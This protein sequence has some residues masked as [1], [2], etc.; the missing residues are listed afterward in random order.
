MNEAQ[1]PPAPAVTRTLARYIVESNPD[2][3]PDAVVHEARRALLHWIGCSLGGCRHEATETALAA[4]G[5]FSG[6]REATVIGRPERVDLLLAALLNGISADVLGFSDTHLKTVIHPGGVVGPAILGLAERAPI[7]GRDF[8]HAFLLGIEVACRAGLSVYPWHYARGWHITG[9]A[10]TFGA[11]AAAGKLL[12]L[13]EQRMTWALGIAATQAAGLREMFGSMCKSLH[14]GRAA[15]NGLSA[16]SLAQ[17]GFTSSEQA[18]E[19]PRG[20]ANVL[21]ESPDLTALIRGLGTDFE[22]LQNTYKP[23]PCGVVIHPVID[24]CVTLKAAHAFN[25]ADIRRIALRVNPLVLELCGR[26]TPATTSQ[27]KLSV[28][29]SAA[30]A[31]IAGRMTEQ[32]Y[33]MTCVADPAVVG[34]REKV[35]AVA[36]AAIREDEADVVIE[37]A[38]GKTLHHHVDFVIGSTRRPMSD[39][40]IEIKFRGLAAPVLP[41][42]TVEQLIAACWAITDQKEASILAR[43]GA[44]QG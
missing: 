26:K 1:N 5:E 10:G 40:D 43:L 20:F 22:V 12:G 25:A 24:G 38:D 6:A 28:Y 44:A 9:T 21:G 18:I 17:K 29:H 35:E 30:A 11:A 14:G 42:E 34:L 36:D 41:A 33:A 32:E 7:S 19:A 31:T 2:D 13:D 16:A 23:F 37:F 39:A 15:Q 27:S 4:F 8:L 3:I